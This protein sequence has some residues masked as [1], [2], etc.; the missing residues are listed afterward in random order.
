MAARRSPQPAKAMGMCN[1]LRVVG[2]DVGGTS[3]KAGVVDQSG[4]VQRVYLIFGEA[5]PSTGGGR[6]FGDGDGV[7]DREG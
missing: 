7:T 5:E 4:S 1:V 3:M 2:L 6:E